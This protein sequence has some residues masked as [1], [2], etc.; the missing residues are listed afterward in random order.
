MCY[1]VYVKINKFLFFFLSFLYIICE[2]SYTVKFYTDQI[3]FT[4][5]ISQYGLSSTFSCN[6]HILDDVDNIKLQG[7]LYITHK[8]EDKMLEKVIFSFHLSLLV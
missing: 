5:Q 3:K 1:P 4:R 6:P 2:T 7:V 8:H